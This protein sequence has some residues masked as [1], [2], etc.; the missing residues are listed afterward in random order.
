MPRYAVHDIFHRRDDPRLIGWVV[1]APDG[2]TLEAARPAHDD[3]YDRSEPGWD[4]DIALTH[5][6]KMRKA[7]RWYGLPGPRYRATGLAAT[8]VPEEGDYPVAVAERYDGPVWVGP[9]RYARAGS[10]GEPLR[11]FAPRTCARSSPTSPTTT[12]SGGDPRTLPQFTAAVGADLRRRGA[13]FALADLIRWCAAVWPLARE[14]PD[15][16]RWATAFLEAPP[17]STP[18]FFTEEDRQTW[19]EDLRRRKG[20]EWVRAHQALLDQEWEYLQSL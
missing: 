20:E 3:E 14:D 8:E 19:L 12:T 1:V 2:I 11:P 6:A 13:A 10:T 17:A 15:P 18:H 16:G 4:D 7:L 5:L 9:G